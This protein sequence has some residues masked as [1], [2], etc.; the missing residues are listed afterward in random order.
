[1]VAQQWG[2]ANARELQELGRIDGAA[3]KND[4]PTCQCFL[5]DAIFLE[6]D[7]RSPLSIEDDAR[8]QAV[9]FDVEV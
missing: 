1:M 4:F 9:G 3:C 7:A 2:L 6:D 8:N 5:L